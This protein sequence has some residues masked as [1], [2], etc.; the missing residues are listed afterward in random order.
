MY[1]TIIIITIITLIFSCE[2][3]IKNQKIAKVKKEEIVPKPK[4][5]IIYNNSRTPQKE[6]D[7]VF[8][9]LLELDYDSKDWGD[10]RISS[11]TFDNDGNIFFLDGKK[12]VIWKTDSLG[13]YIKTF[14]SR[15]KGPGEMTNP[16][17]ISVKD[18]TLWVGDYQQ[19]KYS[20]FDLD[21][22]FL[23]DHGVERLGFTHKVDSVTT[24][25]AFETVEERG[26]DNFHC[27]GFSVKHSE[28]DSIPKVLWKIENKIPYKAYGRDMSTPI[29]VTKERIYIAKNSEST[30]EID[31]YDLRGEKIGLIRKPYAKIPYN[32][33]DDTHHRAKG[34]VSYGGWSKDKLPEIKYKL[35]IDNMMI[36]KNKDLWV[37]QS[38]I[39]DKRNQ[40]TAYVDIYKD[41]VYYARSEFDLLD[42][43]TQ[44]ISGKY[45]RTK[46][47]KLYMNDIF[48]DKFY[49]YKYDYIEKEVASK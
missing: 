32:E 34:M 44:R 7:I 9:K 6:V 48:N 20:K 41:G 17:T 27:K 18:D 2:K 31:I 49:I 5:P 3:Q 16:V 19:K 21:G 40:N 30:F 14:G 13:N 22:N 35:A 47:D 29:K 43:S 38:I 42:R 36:D 28:L 1:K 24:I 46:K 39:R 12:C 8:T 23:Y 26:E 4:T 37:F 15:G 45:L 33:F 11:Y 10:L 25:K